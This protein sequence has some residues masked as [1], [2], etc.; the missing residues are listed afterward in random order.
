MKKSLL[1]SKLTCLLVFFL[2]A[3]LPTDAQVTVDQNKNVLVGDGSPTSGYKFTVIGNTD[4]IGTGVSREFI[5]TNSKGFLALRQRILNPNTQNE[6]SYQELHIRPN[7]GSGGFI[8][9]TEDA[10]ADRW[11][12]GTLPGLSKLVF[13]HG[14]PTSINDHFV[15]DRVNGKTSISLD[16]NVS[17]SS[18]RLIK[19][20]GGTG[21][22]QFGDGLG[23]TNFKI[24]SNLSQNIF[25]VIDNGRVHIDGK[26][27]V[28]SFNNYASAFS[29]GGNLRVHGTQPESD[30]GSDLAGA[31]VVAHQNLPNQN[32]CTRLFFGNGT[33]YQMHFSKR[34]N[35]TTTDLM[36]IADDGTIIAGLLKVRPDG[37]V[38]INYNFNPIL[39][40]FNVYG[41]FR[42]GGDQD[43]A[44]NV[45]SSVGSELIITNEHPVK[46]FYFGNG[47]GYS[48][49]FSK[50]NASTTTD[51]FNISDQGEVSA[52]IFKVAPNGRVGINLGGDT[53][54]AN[55]SM[56]GQ[57]F[58]ESASN[59]ESVPATTGSAM[60]IKVEGNDKKI[61]FGDR[62]T[63][64]LKFTTR[65]SNV[66]KNVLELKDTG[67]VR[68]EDGDVYLKNPTKGIILKQPNGLKCRRITV[69]DSGNLIV[70]DPFDCP[71]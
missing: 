5:N 24:L 36:T 29:V 71:N 7:S 38:G 31:F 39:S 57:I 33:G 25:S 60:I 56:R 10:I 18:D 22:I 62:T 70:S 16:N 66:E 54:P 50:R 48:L 63:Y 47:T 65:N 40:N 14:N 43:V 52:G 1:L 9:F 46:R 17:L 21:I 42:L 12:I 15:V 69:D 4:I 35:S 44:T 27:G 67:E 23:N 49:K 68:V 32:A 6:L 45:G 26:L 11:T 41:H 20:T 61:Y 37:K 58:M 64:N 30:L 8:T 55:L 28:N 13:S 51:I 34:V 2:I 3:N 19:F 59:P 53:P